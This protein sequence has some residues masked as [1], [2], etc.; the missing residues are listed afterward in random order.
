MEQAIGII[1]LAA[2]N[3]SRLGHPKQ[4]LPYKGSSLL[5]NIILQANLLPNG[6]VLLV[7]G[8]HREV[9]EKEFA[10]DFIK[11]VHNSNWEMGMASSIAAGL[12][13]LREFEPSIK[14]CIVTV[15]DQP[16][17][18]TAVFADLI[19]QH[20]KTGKGIVA[21]A[22]GDTFGTPVLFSSAYFDELEKLK[23]NQGA[24]KLL[25]DYKNDLA[26][27]PFAKGAIDIDTMDDYN[28]LIDQE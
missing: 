12:H 22:Y 19:E 2:G 5:R 1:L 16:Y 28:N 20:T 6:L 3:S 21:S 23:G 10:S 27:V 8:A 25:Q 17:V 11:V 9:I 14:F 15:C 4:L 18:T 24:K 26:A 13:A 7:T